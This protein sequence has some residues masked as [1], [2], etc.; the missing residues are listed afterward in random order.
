MM[1][2]LLNNLYLVAAMA[3]ALALLVLWLVTMGRLRKS[4]AD[5]TEFKRRLERKEKLN[6]TLTNAFGD[7]IGF[8]DD[9]DLPPDPSERVREL[10]GQADGQGADTVGTLEIASDRLLMQDL[11]NLDI[12]LFG[13]RGFEGAREDLNECQILL[14]SLNAQSTDTLDLLDRSEFNYIVSL[15]SRLEAFQPHTYAASKLR[16]TIETLR[17][18]LAQKNT[19]L[20]IYKPLDIVPRGQVQRVRS[21][22]ERFLG[23][24]DVYNALKRE[25]I[26]LAQS[27][28]M[29]SHVLIADMVQVGFGQTLPRALIF[30]QSV[31]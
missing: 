7:L 4:N 28:R 13:L 25:Y 17:F 10:F 5:N 2:E 19:F 26:A 20:G 29:E 18:R 31:N 6:T 3:V 16:F 15:A 8:D 27:P 30:D 9:G 24:Q 23:D 14:D 22:H 21:D 12:N 1:T 11:E